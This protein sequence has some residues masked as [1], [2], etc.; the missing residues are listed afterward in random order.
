M[1]QDSDNY[2]THTPKD[3]SLKGNFTLQLFSPNVGHFEFSQIPNFK[4]MVQKIPS[5]WFRFWVKFFFGAKF[6]KSCDN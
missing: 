2:H 5:L 3:Y 1:E 4:I 6:I